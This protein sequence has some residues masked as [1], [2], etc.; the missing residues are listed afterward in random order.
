MTNQEIFNKSVKGLN[1]QGFKQS[2][3]SSTD[4]CAYR[5]QGDKR[6]AIG[7]CIEDEKIAR[8]WD[9]SGTADICSIAAD[10]EA[11][12]YLIFGK[13]V[14]LDFLSELQEAHD[15]CGSPEDMKDALREVAREFKLKMPNCLKEKV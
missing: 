6:C 5:G 2:K 13:R 3:K 9:K 15:H 11:E 14:N 10:F 12:F 7:H 8:K 1:S 4:S